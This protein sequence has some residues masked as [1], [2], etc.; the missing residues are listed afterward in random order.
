VTSINI[1]RS[2]VKFTRRGMATTTATRAT[3][4]AVALTRGMHISVDP[5]AAEPVY[6]GF[7]D[8]IT[9]DGDDATDGYPVQP[10]VPDFVLC[11]LT[12]DVRVV[13][14]TGNV[15]FWLRGE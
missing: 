15:K 5:D 2:T 14:K 9:A 1:D 10:G 13:T 11:A 12:T 4:D 3:A 8:A 6:V 7:S